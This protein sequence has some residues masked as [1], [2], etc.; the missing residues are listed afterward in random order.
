MA[1][2][3]EQRRMVNIT[4]LK[5]I[6]LLSLAARLSTCFLSPFHQHASA[7]THDYII[8]DG[9]H[10]FS[11]YIPRLFVIQLRQYNETLKAIQC[12]LLCSLVVIGCVMWYSGERDLY[13][14]STIA[15]R[16]RQLLCV[17]SVNNTFQLGEWRREEKGKRRVCV[18]WNKEERK[19]KIRKVLHA[20][21]RSSSH[22]REA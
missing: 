4:G 14:C 9:Q 18:G 13:V 1:N 19:R 21:R 15:A 6:A 12:A 3:D 5:F 8:Q 22:R 20:T 10:E 16:E 2:R 11:G 7:Y 17:H